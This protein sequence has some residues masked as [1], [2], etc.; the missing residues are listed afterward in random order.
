MREIIIYLLEDSEEDAYIVKRLMANSGMQD[1]K[2][3]SYLTLDALEKAIT[4]MP[5]DV[6][7]SDMNLQESRGLDTLIRVKRFAGD[8]PI[9]VLT[10]YEEESIGYDAIQLGAQ[11]YIPKSELTGN[12]L[13][14]SVRFSRERFQLLKSLEEKVRRDPLTMLPNREAFDER[15][16]EMISDGERYNTP[17][18]L[19]FFDVDKFKGIN[20][21][22][23]HLVGD[24]ILKAIGARLNIFKRSSD[25]VSRYA[26]DEFVMIAKNVGDVEE[27]EC[28]VRSKFDMIQDSYAVESDEG[29]IINIDACAS[30]GA[31]LYGTHGKTVDELIAE[32]DKAMYTGKSNGCGWSIAE[33]TKVESV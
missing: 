16:K 19:L 31:A 14:R 22:H 15:I 23:G 7:I 29:K 21:N 9:I 32:A 6:I 27:L 20:D 25:F 12:L 24:Q 30:I 4:I 33:S 26:G 3:R 17:F 18:A 11:D 2:L 5:P 13:K 8:Y 28:L 10:G 1:F